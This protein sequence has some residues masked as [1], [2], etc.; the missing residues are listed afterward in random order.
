LDS[1]FKDEVHYC[2]NKLAKLAHDNSTDKGFWDVELPDQKY[3]GPLPA[4]WQDVWQLQR[5]FI[6]ERL[7]LIHSEVS[8]AL[9]DLRKMRGI[10]DITDPEI[11][12]PAGIDQKPTGFGSE[13]ADI[14]IRVF[15][16]A[17]WLGIDLGKEI[18]RKM[19]YNKGRPRKHGKE[20]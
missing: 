12:G 19:E 3:K 1:H 4:T 17:G 2:I 20:F 11:K 18:I 8:E 16:L 7:C 15:D 13:L 9:E 14:V 6:S 10:R 5:L